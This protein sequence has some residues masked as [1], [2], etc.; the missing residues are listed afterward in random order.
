[1]VNS[2][3]IVTP[4]GDCEYKGTKICQGAVTEEMGKFVK[5][6]SRGRVKTNFASKVPQP[7]PLV[8]RDTGPGKGMMMIDFIRGYFRAS[9]PLI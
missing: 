8:G 9:S 7:Y 5:I 1:M 3:N 6:C 4:G 2:Q